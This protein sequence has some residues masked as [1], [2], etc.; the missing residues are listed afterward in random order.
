M[1]NYSLEEFHRDCLILSAQ[2]VDDFQ[3]TCIVMLVRGG[4]SVGAWISQSFETK[5]IYTSACFPSGGVSGKILFV[6]DI[7]RS[8]ETI[9]KVFN[10]TLSRE[11]LVTYKLACIHYSPTESDFVP[12]FYL[13]KISSDD[14]IVYPWESTR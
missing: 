2:I 11:I 10:N 14:W 8:A 3:P 4:V 5:L 7:C 1:V 13:R 6:S 9:R 12:Y